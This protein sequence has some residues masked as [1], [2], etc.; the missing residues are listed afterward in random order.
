MEAVEQFKPGELDFVYIDAKH[1]FKHV[2]EDVDAWAKIVR[3]GGIVSG[4][5]YGHFKYKDRGLE[6]KRA[7]DNYVKEHRIRMLFLVNQN[8]Q[9]TWF[10]VKE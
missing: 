8:Y 9:T 2:S 3:V 6:A 5:D 1:D 10:F 4:H 7:I